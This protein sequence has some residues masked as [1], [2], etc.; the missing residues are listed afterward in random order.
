MTTRTVTLGTG[1]TVTLGAYVRA[2]RTVLARP[3]DTFRH[4]L[5]G[6]W[7][8]TGREI[9]RDFRNGLHARIN[10]G[11]PRS[12]PWAPPPPRGR[13]D[14]PDWQRAAHQLAARVNTP[15][16]LVRVHEC[17]AEFRARLSERLSNE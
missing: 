16:L 2:W 6:W 13:K 1:E 12:A 8:V 11:V 4:G 7:P 3:D 15:R 9:L 5:G 14:D 17:P 10:S